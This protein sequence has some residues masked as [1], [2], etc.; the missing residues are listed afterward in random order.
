MALRIRLSAGAVSDLEDI[1]SY[2]MA[3]SP[4]GAENA[5]RD[6]DRTISLLA[7]FP[8]L[9]RDTDIA[10]VSVQPTGRYGYLVY[11]ATIGDELVVVH[12]RH[13]SRESPDAS[14]LK[15]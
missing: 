2:L 7:D 10:G 13:R 9:G 11:H 4:M 12:I 6:I 3:R 15:A 14:D 5:R 8:G 1:R